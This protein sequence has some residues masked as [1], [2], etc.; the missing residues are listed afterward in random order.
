MVDVNSLASGFKEVFNKEPC[1]IASAPG[2]LDFLNTHQDYKGLPVVSVAINLRT[3]VAVGDSHDGRFKVYTNS[4]RLSD[5]FDLRNL[6]L[7]GSG[8]FGDYVRASIL[9]LMRRGCLIKPCEIYIDSDVPIAAGLGS[10]A[11]LE[12]GVVGAL[13]ELLSLGLNVKEVAEI[14]FEAENKIMNIPC[15]RLDQYASAYGGILSINTKPPYDVER[16]NFSKGVFIVVDS[17]IKHSTADIHP[18]RQLELNRG[19]EELLK[20]NLPESLKSKLGLKYWEPRWDELSEE[21]LMPYLTKVDYIA[22]KRIVFTLRMHR[23]TLLALKILKGLEVDVSE[24]SKVL[25]LKPSEVIDMLERNDVSLRLI[26][27][28]MTYQH[29]LLS[30]LYDVSLPQIDKIVNTLL[31]SGVYGAKLSGAGLG[32][33]VIA[34]TNSKDVAVN[35][36]N[37]VL[38][39]CASR[40][41]ITSV[42][43]GLQVMRW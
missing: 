31:E 41:W 5:S 37:K 6:K 8:W 3:F 40:G 25:R 39:C 43:S 26:G 22:S 21:E 38:S 27:A 4:L 7:V 28:V 20:L 32:G 42:D 35:A 23:S 13:N 1:L 30:E 29:R 11:A 18:K 36:L 34:L 12:V 16:L 2:R 14:A 24:V 9:A 19:L 15:G 17:G 10:S 33:S